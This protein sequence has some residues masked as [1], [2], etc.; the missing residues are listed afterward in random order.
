MADQVAI[1][2]EGRIIARGTPEQI[3]ETHGG[4]E[5]LSVEAPPS[6]AEFLRR[7]LALSVSSSNGRVEVEMKEKGDALRVLTA[8]EASGIPW[9]GFATKTDTLE[10]VFVRLVG[11]MD[12]GE[13]KSGAPA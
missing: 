4:P 5:R 2:H 10:D 9:Q 3:I 11:R 7:T 13:I 6:M 1:I 12:E 8:I